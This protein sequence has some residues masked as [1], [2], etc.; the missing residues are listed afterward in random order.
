MTPVQLL[1]LGVLIFSIYLGWSLSRGHTRGVRLYLVAL[2][3]ALSL[4]GAAAS[5]VLGVPALVESLN[6]MA[7]ALSLG[8]L[9]S[10]PTL[11]EDQVRADLSATRLYRPLMPADMLSWKAW[12]KVVDKLGAMQAALGY[13]GLFVVALILDFAALMS[14]ADAGDRAFAIAPLSA[15]GLFAILSAFWLYRAARRLVS[16]S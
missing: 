5:Q 3:V 13:M 7:P 10:G 6:V 8:A 9:P 2:V 16:N 15:P 11:W 1:V 14:A 12:L 4:F